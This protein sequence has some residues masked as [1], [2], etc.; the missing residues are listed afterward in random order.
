MY[1][2][3]EGEQERLSPQANMVGE[4]RLKAFLM[5]STQTETVGGK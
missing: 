1:G 3:G 2:R 5:F 4:T